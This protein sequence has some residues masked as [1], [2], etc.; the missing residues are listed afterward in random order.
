M[1]EATN[2]LT[3]NFGESNIYRTMKDLFMNLTAL[4]TPYS[5]KL[6]NLNDSINT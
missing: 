4:N 1:G 3:Q 5:L 6:C 2:S